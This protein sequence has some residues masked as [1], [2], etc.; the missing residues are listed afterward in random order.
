MD[1]AYKPDK[2]REA[3]QIVISREITEKHATSF[4]MKTR[5]LINRVSVSSVPRS[6]KS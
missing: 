3:S 1:C 2:K 5:A 4:G 6:K